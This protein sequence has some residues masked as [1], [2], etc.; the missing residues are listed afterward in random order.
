MYT[1]EILFLPYYLIG[2]TTQEY[3]DP[4]HNQITSV[5]S[6]CKTIFGN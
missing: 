5:K 3:I 2:V 1:M 6:R 4:R